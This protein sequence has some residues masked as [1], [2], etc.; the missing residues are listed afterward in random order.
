MRIFLL[1]FLLLVA[2]QSAKTGLA[3]IDK[4]YSFEA[5]VFKT[6]ESIPLGL[7][8]SIGQ[9]WLPSSW[10]A[11]YTMR[12]AVGPYFQLG[13][14]HGFYLEPRFE[15]AYYPE[16]NTPFEPETGLRLGWRHDHL[17]VFIGGR[18][19]LGNGYRHE[20]AGEYEHIPAG[21]KPELGIVWGFDF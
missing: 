14:P 13:L 6:E 10:E 18:Y 21:F 11:D 2:C 15:A 1:L 16:L 7:R 3:Y 5:S 8:A 12:Y 20:D 4:G 19:P 17:E 9:V